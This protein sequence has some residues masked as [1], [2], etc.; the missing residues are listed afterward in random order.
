MDITVNVS[1]VQVGVMTSQIAVSKSSPKAKLASRNRNPM[2]AMARK[3][4]KA[5]NPAARNMPQASPPP[6]ARFRHARPSAFENPPFGGLYCRTRVGR[7]QGKR[8][9]DRNAVSP[10][11]AA[12]AASIS[13]RT[14]Q[15]ESA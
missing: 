3:I 1:A 15:P 14:T 13:R 7:S 12:E 10:Q 11:V 4:A 6:R 9:P 2:E 5:E 8:L